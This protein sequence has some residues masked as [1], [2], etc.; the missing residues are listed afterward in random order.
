MMSVEQSVEWE[1]AG[2]T[3]VLGENLPQCHFVHRKSHI[4]WPGLE[5]A[6]GSRRLTAWGLKS[7]EVR[8]HSSALTRDIAVNNS[9]ANVQL[10]EEVKQN[11]LLQDF[12]MCTCSSVSVSQSA[13]TCSQQLLRREHSHALRPE[14]RG[15]H[16]TTW[17]LWYQWLRA[18]T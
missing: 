6:L 15:S 8:F 4:I 7:R 10:I 3:E 9:W 16:V 11:T 5:S 2:E 1:L 12:A 14:F 13:P 17:R 18:Y